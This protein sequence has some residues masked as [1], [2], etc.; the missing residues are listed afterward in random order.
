[1]ERWPLD[2]ETI[3][4]CPVA[5]MGVEW[6]PESVPHNKHVSLPR[7]YCPLPSFHS[8]ELDWKWGGGRG[9][10]ERCS[11]SGNKYLSL[12]PIAEADGC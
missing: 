7:M 4:H 5:R 6:L 1:M 2:Q 10:R 12:L 11:S 9:K 3:T 8:G